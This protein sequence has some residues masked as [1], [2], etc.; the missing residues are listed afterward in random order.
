MA[1]AELFYFD[2]RKII[3]QIHRALFIEQED[4]VILQQKGIA[5]IL[6]D[7]VHAV[8]DRL[9]LVLGI[10]QSA[11]GVNGVLIAAHFAAVLADFFASAFDYITRADIGK[12]VIFFQ[13]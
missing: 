11:D 2:C 8:A 7:K 6:H 13:H 4:A 9:L 1:Q 5:R 12:P 3:I 10:N